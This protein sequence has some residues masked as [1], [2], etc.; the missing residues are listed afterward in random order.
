MTITET[1]TTEAT[2]GKTT[3]RE[4]RTPTESRKTVSI[5]SST[6]EPVCNGTWSKWFNGNSPS[7]HSKDD[8]ELLQPILDK[9]CPDAPYVINYIECEAVSFPH[10]PIS[11]T[12][13]NVTCDLKEGL[14][15]NYN[16]RSSQTN[17]CLDY[18]IRVCCEYVTTPSPSTVTTVNSTSPF[19]SSTTEPVCS[20]GRAS[21]GKCSEMNTCPPKTCSNGRI[22]VLIETRNGCCQWECFCECEVWGDPHYRT[23][24]GTQYDFFGNCTYTLVEEVIPKYN[25]TVLVDNYFCLEGIPKSCPKGLI[26]FY[27]ENNVTISPGNNNKLTVNGH[28][29]SVP[30]FEQCRKKVDIEPYKRTCIFDHC[31]RITP[32]ICSSL[33]AAAEACRRAGFCVDWRPFTN[34][35]CNFTCQNN[36]VYKACPE[37]TCDRCVNYTVKI[38]YPTSEEGCYC[39]DGMMMTENDTECVSSCDTDCK[40]TVVTQKIVNGTCKTDIE[41]KQCKGNCFSST[42]FNFKTNSM[43]HICQCCQERETAEKTV[44]LQCDDGSTSAYTYTDIKSCTCKECES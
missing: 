17:M 23:F 16:E 30:P 6:T 43:N 9:L 44:N 8:S 5:P 12:K 35:L 21:Q 19:T 22:P 32:I 11:E 39:P 25:F 13:D 3:S 1:T 24:F 28:D 29:T 10:R 36:L 40:P 4:V 37:K 31:R 18:R 7:I 38:G 26:I 33:E 34:G 20:C 2:T 15:C 27:K 42:K 41:I 14:I